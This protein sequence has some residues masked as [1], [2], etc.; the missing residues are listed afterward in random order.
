MGTYDFGVKVLRLWLCSDLAI[1]MSLLHSL[2]D[3]CAFP[4]HK[5]NI[6]IMFLVWPHLIGIAQSNTVYSVPVLSMTN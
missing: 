1:V 6:T 2:Y 5:K 3:Y 4:D